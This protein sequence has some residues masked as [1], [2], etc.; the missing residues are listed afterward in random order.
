MLEA[1]EDVRADERRGLA[2]V[3]LG[4]QRRAVSA[5]EAGNGRTGD[6]AA[7]LLLE[8]AQDG[9]VE[10][11]AAL[12]DDVPAEVIGRMGTDD[13]VERVLDDRHG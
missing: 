5:H 9:I 11:G 1:R 4:V 8:R 6:V 13:L 3:V 2:A 12:Y 7:D 10:E